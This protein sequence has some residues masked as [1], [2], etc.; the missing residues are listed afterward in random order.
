MNWIEERIVILLAGTVLDLLIGD[1]HSLWHPVQGIG[2]LITKTEHWIRGKLPDKIAGGFLVVLVTVLSTGIPLFLLTLADWISPWLKLALSCIM[3][4]Q[5]LAM[6]SLKTES[7][8]V[9]H[10]LKKDDIEGPNGARHAVSMIVGRDT[11]VLDESGIIKAAV[12]TVAENSSDGVI[13]PLLFILIFGIPGGFFYKSVNTMDSMIGYKNEKY[14]HFGTAAAKLDD[15]V[16]FL[17][18]R[19]AA[20]AMILAAFL[21]PGFD[22]K[23]AYRIWRRDRR[24]HASPNSAQTESAC[25]GALHVQLAGDAVYFGKKVKKPTLGDPDRP[26]ET[27]DIRRANRLLYGMSFLV[28]GC[29][30]GVLVWIGAGC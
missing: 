8:K 22:G 25:A 18:S 30:I 21:L 10:A 19:L 16:N 9:Y 15:V 24:K 1:P 26:V 17:P 5:L 27:E 11:S 6:K 29:G 4:W 28:L 20:L 12:E 7:M 14:L 2:W 13:A 3:C 23:N